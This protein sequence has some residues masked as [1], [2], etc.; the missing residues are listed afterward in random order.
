M[1]SIL[2]LVG[3]AI[4]AFVIFVSK[5]KKDNVTIIGEENNEEPIFK[6]NIISENINIE[7]NIIMTVD[8]VFTITGKGTVVVGKIIN[9]S[10]Q[11]GDEVTIQ[12]DIVSKNIT[13][14]VTAMEMFRKKITVANTGDLVGVM[15]SDIVKE[16]IK[17]GD[18]ITK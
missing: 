17:C 4:F 12:S 15:L 3:C 5:N 6:D 10:L 16:D 1:Y 9:G 8:D 7:G 13:T 18:Y 2:I 14:T 11:V